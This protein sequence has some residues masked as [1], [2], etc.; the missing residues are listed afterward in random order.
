MEM[1]HAEYTNAP[2]LPL[3]F[4]NG[5]QVW[6]CKWNNLVKLFIRFTSI[7]VVFRDRNK[8][9]KIWKIS[10]YFICWLLLSK[11]NSSAVYKA[12]WLLNIF[13]ANRIEGS[14]NKLQRKQWPKIKKTTGTM[15]TL[16]YLSQHVLYLRHSQN[17]YN[18]SSFVHF[19]SLC[20]MF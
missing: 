5:R 16:F 15:I 18:R 11:A 17:T 9:K 10:C 4:V 7:S 14:I 12:D 20:A 19:H 2:R 13:M 6:G 8:K 3:I 1:K